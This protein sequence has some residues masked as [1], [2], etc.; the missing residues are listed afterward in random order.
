M[1]RAGGQGLGSALGGSTGVMVLPFLVLAL[2]FL[3]VAAAERWTG[4]PHGGTPRLGHA[5]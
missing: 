1:D 3:A 5:H 2:L 4:H